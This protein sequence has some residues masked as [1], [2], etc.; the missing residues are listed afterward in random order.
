MRKKLYEYTGYSLSVHTV[1]S[2]T[3]KRYTIKG[4][5]GISRQYVNKSSVGNV[6]YSNGFITDCP[7]KMIE[8]LRMVLERKKVDVANFNSRVIELERELKKDI[9]E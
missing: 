9:S 3:E 5:T 2:E 1:E 4:S 6:G 8:H 7:K